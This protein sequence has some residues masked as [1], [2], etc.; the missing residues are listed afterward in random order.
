MEIDATDTKANG[1]PKREPNEPLLVYSPREDATPEGELAA[2]AAVYRF[3]L[4]H[5]EKK[6][7]RVSEGEEAA[8]RN[9]TGGTVPKERN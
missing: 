2:L 1:E 4:Q 7:A 5:H 6:D 3:V 8:E 9:R